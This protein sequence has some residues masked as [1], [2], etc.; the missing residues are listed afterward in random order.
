MYY[1]AKRFGYVK[2][3]MVRD[4]KCEG[5]GKIHLSTGQEGPGG[6]EI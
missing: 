2:E 6:V 1:V 4:C 5:K 3:A